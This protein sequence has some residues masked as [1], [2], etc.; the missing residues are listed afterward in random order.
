MTIQCF[1]ISTTLNQDKKI[2]DISEKQKKQTQMDTTHEVLQSPAMAPINPCALLSHNRSYA[3]DGEIMAIAVI[4]VFLIFI[5]FLVA[6][7]YLNM[8]RKSSKNSAPVDQNHG[9]AYQMNYEDIV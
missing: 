7:P 5:F 9:N 3:I 2:L 1:I 6:F 8:L 4:I